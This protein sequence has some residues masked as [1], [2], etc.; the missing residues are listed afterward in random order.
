MYNQIAFTR[1]NRNFLKNPHKRGILVQVL[2]NNFL[3]DT[4]IEFFTEV[5]WKAKGNRALME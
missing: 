3:F 1:C 5:A 4:K 2:F